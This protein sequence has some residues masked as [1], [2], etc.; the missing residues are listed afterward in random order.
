MPF[1]VVASNIAPVVV[2][3]RLEAV[4]RALE[5]KREGRNVLIRDEN[6]REYGPGDFDLFYFDPRR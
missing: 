5:L 6:G 3:T 4:R 2:A 1:T